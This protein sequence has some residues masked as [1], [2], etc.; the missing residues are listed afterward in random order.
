MTDPAIAS[1][2]D[3]IY[4]ATRRDVLAFITAK[5][6]RTADISDIFQEI[7]LELYRLLEKRGVQYVTHEKA[8]VM[9]IARH[10]LAK[11]YT[12]LDRLK[13][14]VSMTTA[15]HREDDATPDL[16][17]DDFS[18]EEFAINDLLLEEAWQY[19]QTKPPQVRKIFYL[20]YDIGL[21][22]AETAQLLSM[23]ESNVKNNLY[24]TLKA[25]RNLLQ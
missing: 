23:T 22:I 3:A 1:R 20:I 6:A 2:F 4:D 8:L 21:T 18:T 19:I 17:L 12:L 24:R 9:R 16:P 7:Y 11:H 25:L 13:M 10:K 5:C 15:T 14:F